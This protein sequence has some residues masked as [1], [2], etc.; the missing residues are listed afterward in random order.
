MKVLRSI[1]SSDSKNRFVADTS[2][3]F[4]VYGP[5][6]LFFSLFSYSDSYLINV[7]LISSSG[8]REFKNSSVFKRDQRYSRM[9]NDAITQLALDY[10]RKECTKTDS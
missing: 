5:R 10:P 3:H 8:L 1:S 9:R 6:F 4:E 2:S 7:A